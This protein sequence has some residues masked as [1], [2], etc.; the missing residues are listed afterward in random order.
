METH[1]DKSWRGL[2]TDS[3]EGYGFCH[4]R[5]IFDQYG[6]LCFSY[7]PRTDRK[8][9]VVVKHGLGRP[10][11]TLDPDSLELLYKVCPHSMT[12]SV[13]ISSG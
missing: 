2:I 10:A 1:I 6:S 11:K 13:R 12:D 4:A 7:L 5:D 3:Q 9:H 8:S